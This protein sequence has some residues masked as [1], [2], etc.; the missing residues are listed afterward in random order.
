MAENAGM[1]QT[2]ETYLVGRKEGVNAYR[3]NRHVKTGRIGQKKT[4]S[5]IEK[6]LTG[7]IGSAIKMGSNGQLELVSF[8][9][10]TINGLNWAVIG[11]ISLNEVKQPIQELIQ[12]TF[13]LGLVMAGFVI[14]IA[15]FTTHIIANPLHQ[16]MRAANQ[17]ANGDWSAKACEQSSDELGQLG[18]SFN[19]MVKALN[20][21]TVS[22]EYMDNII[23]SMTDLLI[24]TSRSGL[25][26][27]INRAD[28]F[29]YTPNG[30]I[31]RSIEDIFKDKTSFGT[32]Q[33]KSLIQTGFIRN[34][35]TTLT[36]KDTQKIPVLVL[37][38]TLYDPQKSSW[39]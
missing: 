21:I 33:T 16:L 30:L 36:T 1:D 15:L 31:G 17:I 27:R 11:T 22:R 32:S 38:S 8:S 9:P 23:Q 7:K 14:A 37:G 13:M 25:I 18:G 6:A 26:E 35:K 2:G 39:S 28:Q 10:L 5:F 19:R 24:V 12:I 20:T 3:S 29:G 4:D 34:V